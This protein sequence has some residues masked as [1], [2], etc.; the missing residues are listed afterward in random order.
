MKTPCSVRSNMSVESNMSVDSNMSVNMTIEEAIN[1]IKNGVVPN[2]KSVW[3]DLGCGDGL[4]TRALA[5]IMGIG[6]TIY[7]VDENRR[8]LGKIEAVPGIRIEKIVGNFE[9]DE[10]Q[11]QD[12]D[13]ILLANSLHFIKDK[14]FFAQR[15]KRWM[16]N[17]GRLI[18][19]E[20]DTDIPNRWVPYPISFSSLQKLFSPLGFGIEKIAEHKS[21]YNRAGMYAA[22][23]K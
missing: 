14:S 5:S 12:L 17:D 4:F 16:N 10:L 15:A 8:A 19:V 2:E 1:L 13:G 22:V 18:I 9:K 20:Y 3:A 7:A 6:S 11:L 23:V 21:I